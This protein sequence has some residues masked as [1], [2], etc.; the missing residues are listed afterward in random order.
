MITKSSDRGMT[1]NTTGQFKEYIF[2]VVFD[3]NNSDILYASGDFNGEDNAIRI[4]KSTDC[5]ESWNL[6]Y[7]NILLNSDGVVD[8]QIH[9]NLLIIYTMTNGIYMLNLDA[10]DNINIIKNK[11]ELTLYPNPSDSY[12]FCNSNEIFNF[13][14]LIDS[15]GNI[16]NEFSP[17]AK[18]FALDISSLSKGIYIALFGNN[19][20]TILKK[21]VKI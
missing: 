4:H 1:W 9:D 11:T 15:S 8:M 19:N 7:S 18:E 17:H 13:V 12:I 6:Y 5:G 3:E 10:S 21:I 14:R 16:I 2:T 20:K